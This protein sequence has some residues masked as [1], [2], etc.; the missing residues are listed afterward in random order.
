LWGI[1]KLHSERRIAW[2]E[3]EEKREAENQI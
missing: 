3:D 1:F 2:L